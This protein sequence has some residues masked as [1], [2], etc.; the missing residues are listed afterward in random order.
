VPG[1]GGGRSAY[2]NIQGRF[3]L[4]LLRKRVPD[5]RVGQLDVGQPLDA[6]GEV[7]WRRDG[8]RRA[9]H[10]ARAAGG[11]QLG[12]G[13]AEAS[14]CTDNQ[15][16]RHRGRKCGEWSRVSRPECAACYDSELLVRDQRRRPYCP[17]IL[18]YT[19]GG[20]GGVASE[21]V[22]ESRNCRPPQVMT[23]GLQY[24]ISQEP[25]LSTGELSTT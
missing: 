9:I 2:H 20:G 18:T 12:Q 21:P 8:A 17:E 1:M 5:A 4:Q 6:L 15:R 16:G 19:D 11:V 3:P 25:R 13:G 14:G 24:S 7:A 10:L 23:S 22:D